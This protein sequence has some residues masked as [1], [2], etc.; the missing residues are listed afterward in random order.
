VTL[1]KPTPTWCLKNVSEIP[2]VTEEEARRIYETF[3]KAGRHIR[4]WVSIVSFLELEEYAKYKQELMNLIANKKLKPILVSVSME[5]GYMGIT[6]LY[7]ARVKTQSQQLVIV[8][9]RIAVIKSSG[10]ETGYISAH[11]HKL[12]ELEWI[13]NECKFT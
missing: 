8:N 12:H 10:R 7:A 6:A 3:A 9:E 11:Y 4:K 2:E 1:R 5:E 13:M